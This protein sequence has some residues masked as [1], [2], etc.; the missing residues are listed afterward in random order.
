MPRIR[1]LPRPPFSVI[2]A[3]L[4]LTATGCKIPPA[5]PYS[6]P[7]TPTNGCIQYYR[8]MA[9]GVTPFGPSSPLT[10]SAIPYDR[11]AQSFLAPGAMQISIVSLDLQ[12]HSQNSEPLN[13]ELTL[14]LEQDNFGSPA[15]A[16]LDVATLP[17]AGS[18]D[19]PPIVTSAPA[20]YG[21][22]FYG[23]VRLTPGQVY[24]LVLDHSYQDSTVNYVE[25]VGGGQ[26]SPPAGP[27]L[28]WNIYAQQWT[29]PAFETSE[30]S[31][32]FRIGC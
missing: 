23:G 20:F 13:G 27:A 26:P 3:G 19:T 11:V 5:S 21:F 25:W 17:L 8:P 22:S 2:I 14:T 24:W 18:S 15:G 28:F 10:F 6:S 4:L 16:A 32:F 29:N 12:A 7:S 9:G 1:L 30:A 31:L